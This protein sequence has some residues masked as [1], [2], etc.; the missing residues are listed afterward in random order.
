MTEEGPEGR[1][2]S[3]LNGGRNTI[4]GAVCLVICETTAWNKGQKSESGEAA[5][6][7]RGREGR[8]GHLEEE[9]LQRE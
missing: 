6:L 4:R 1:E 7:L 9:A 3:R 2:Q 5:G 8:G